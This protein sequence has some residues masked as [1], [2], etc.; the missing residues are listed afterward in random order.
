MQ[1]K[2]FY[3]MLAEECPRLNEG[4]VEL[5]T[6]IGIP[7]ETRMGICECDKCGNVY[8][9]STGRELNYIMFCG[10]CSKDLIPCYSCSNVMDKDEVKGDNYCEECYNNLSYCD[11]CGDISDD[12]TS[13]LVQRGHGNG[14]AEERIM[15]CEGCRD[16]SF[17]R[18]DNCRDWFEE[19]D[20][21]CSDPHICDGCYQEEYTTCEECGDIIHNDQSYYF[22]DEEETLCRS[23]YNNRENSLCDD[24]PYIEVQ[25]IRNSDHPFAIGMELEFE[26]AGNRRDICWYVKK[27]LYPLFWCK[28]D[29]SLSSEN[30]LEIPCQPMSWEYYQE[31]GR[32][33][34]EGLVDYL[35]DKGCTAWKTN[36]GIH[37]SLDKEGFNTA[38]TYRFLKFFY[39][40]PEFIFKISRRNF[41]SFE[42]WCDCRSL[43][44]KGLAQKF[45]EEC[46][47]S[48]GSKYE[49][50]NLNHSS[51]YEVRIFAGTLKKSSIFANIEFCRGVYEYTRDAKT[52]DVSVKGF[53]KYVRQFQDRFKHLINLHLPHLIE[54]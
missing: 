40:N 28:S 43:D 12:L 46:K 14:R 37:I 11:H 15:V 5:L 10:E 9:Y 54:L 41:S 33:Q 16:D 19:K 4:T 6:E 32:D 44:R 8:M 42:K 24:E 34:I 47:R 53:E 1:T 22:E 17:F 27:N 25:R 3:I 36:A 20:E 21:A 48:G 13:I 45:K 35:S 29:G 38:H 30:G 7:V 18:C 52:K 49:A 31:K 39:E 2:Q 26:C 23:C 51:H 50:V